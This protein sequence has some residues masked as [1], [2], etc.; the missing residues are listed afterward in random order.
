M[1]LNSKYITQLNMNSTNA[2][3][4]FKNCRKCGVNK[5]LDEFH[6]Q[7]NVKCG[8]TARCNECINA[9]KR[10][11]N[12]TEEQ[13]EK[14]RKRTRTRRENMTEEQREKYR[15]RDLETKQKKHT[16][17][18][19]GIKEY[20]HG[21]YVKHKHGNQ[22]DFI[23]MIDELLEKQDGYCELTNLKFDLT[24]KFLR[25]SL[26]RIE[27][28]ADGGKYEKGNVQLVVLGFNQFRKHIPNELML[29][30]CAG[31]LMSHGYNVGK[32]ITNIEY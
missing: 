11:E 20:T 14:Q 29:K 5:P 25:P 22:E 7:S 27:F 4:M 19:V 32:E 26:D 17:R 6:K 8:R 3:D 31:Y 21:L 16:D 13:L 2:N 10:K 1:A 30:M 28:G 12:I 23:K 9:N 15:K 18:L 24:N